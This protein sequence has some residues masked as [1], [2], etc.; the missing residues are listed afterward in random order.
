MTFHGHRASGCGVEDTP[1]L[2]P[3][4][5]L[6]SY[7]DSTSSFPTLVILKGQSPENRKAKLGHRQCLLSGMSAS[8]DWEEAVFP[9]TADPTFSAVR[10][11]S[12]ALGM[13]VTA[14][15]T[16]QQGMKQYLMKS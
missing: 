5:H 14:E 12:H 6:T 8:Q 13:H 9:P 1:L 10:V 16:A 4:T 2:F 11:A 15:G 7:P 3:Y